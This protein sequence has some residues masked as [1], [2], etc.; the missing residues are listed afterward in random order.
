MTGQ[1]TK[2][3]ISY[4]SISESI[5]DRGFCWCGYYVAVGIDQGN[6]EQ[7]QANPKP[8]TA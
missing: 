8:D 1:E 7:N 5:N 4:G 6:Q 2:G 3:I